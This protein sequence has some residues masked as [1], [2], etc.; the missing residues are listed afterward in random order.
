[1]CHGSVLKTLYLVGIF[2]S[3]LSCCENRLSSELRRPVWTCG[4]AP[5]DRRYADIG[6]GLLPDS[7]FRIVLFGY[8]P[9]RAFLFHTKFVVL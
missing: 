1:V 2:S 6:A 4:T 9:D 8:L 5:R 7:G 3:K